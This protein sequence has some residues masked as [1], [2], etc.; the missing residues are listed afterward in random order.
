MVRAVPG[1]LIQCD[2]AVMQII[3]ELDQSLQNK[4]VIEYLDEKNVF[5]KEEYVTLIQNR[6]AEILED[7]TYRVNDEAQK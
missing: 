1:T 7:Q 4:V 6:V 2:E 3:R 5:V